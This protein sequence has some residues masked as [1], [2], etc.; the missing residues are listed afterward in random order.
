MIS[1]CLFAENS[2]EFFFEFSAARATQLFLLV[3]TMKFLTCYFVIPIAVTDAKV[4]LQPNPIA[5]NVSIK[6][7][8][9]LFLIMWSVTC[10]TSSRNQEF[11]KCV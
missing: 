5:D 7:E 4:P 1:R 6:G 10:L 3:Q 9:A 8:G 11:S 2:T